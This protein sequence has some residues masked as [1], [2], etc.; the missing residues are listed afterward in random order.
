[1]TKHED[2][3][4]FLLPENPEGSDINNSDVVL[5]LPKAIRHGGTATTMSL[6]SFGIDFSSC[7]VS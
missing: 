2:S 5:R 4:K 3:C 6:M 1:M 7:N